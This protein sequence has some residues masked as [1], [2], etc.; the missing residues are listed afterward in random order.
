M[1]VYNITFMVDP[2]LKSE[3]CRWMT[4]EGAPLLRQATLG[5]DTLSSL[6]EVEGQPIP[7]DY[8][9][10]FA[11]QTHFDDIDALHHWAGKVVPQALESFRDRF[12]QESQAFATTLEVMDAILPSRR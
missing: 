3:F 12:G 8:G 9:A 2:A 10:S 6:L 4:E 11:Y 7:S 1:Y 5:E